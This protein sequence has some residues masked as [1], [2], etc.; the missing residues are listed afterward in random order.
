MQDS[1]RIIRF[2]KSPVRESRTPGSV[3]GISRKGYVYST[4]FEIHIVEL[5]KAAEG[6]HEETILLKWAKF[7][8]AETREEFEMIAKI[9]P[10]IGEAYEE[11]LRMSAD[12]EKRQE[13]EA[14]QKAILDHNYLMRVNWENGKAEGKEEGKAE[15]K[16]EGKDEGIKGAVSIL[17]E[18][19][20]PLQTIKIKIQEKY[21]LSEEASEQYLK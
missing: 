6:E 7:I 12:E 14:R 16:E 3:R 5:P 15:G 2:A 10:F 8:H 11:L 4:K 17:E 1:C 19:G 20:I 9:D 13:Y 21:N 18:L